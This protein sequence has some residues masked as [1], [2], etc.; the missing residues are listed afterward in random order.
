MRKI[1]LLLL[2]AGLFISPVSA[3]DFTA[4]TAP[5]VAEEYMPENTE[6]FSEGLWYVIKVAIS[7]LQPSLAE[8]AESCLSLAAIVLLIC[9]FQCASS[10][11]KQTIVLAGNLAISVLLILPTNSLVALGAE[12]VKKLTEYQ[13]MLLPVM[14]GALAAQGGVTTS[15]ALY[16]GTAVFNTV[17]ST[18]VANLIIPMIYIFLC[19]SISCS[20]VGQPLLR[21]IRDFVKWGMT[22]SLKTLLYVF[23]GYLSITKVISGTVDASTVKATKLAISGT[24]P[25]VGGLISDATETI[26]V[27]AG[28]MKNAAG[29]YGLLAALSIWIGPFLKIGSQYILLKLT[30]AACGVIGNKENT[31]LIADFS[32]AM[33]MLL[34]MTG[35]VCLLLL[36]ST[37]CFMKGLS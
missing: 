29:T 32:G 23:T 36:V 10:K 13:K 27:S 30:A 19:L 33:G 16:S 21:N 24:V 25:I 22:W 11:G 6:T 26:L 8:A 2:I 35:T 20:V 1:V 37:V 17:L 31:T 5:D 4:P 18:I 7:K 15:A 34:A 3:L 28:L 12:T 14:T 9:V